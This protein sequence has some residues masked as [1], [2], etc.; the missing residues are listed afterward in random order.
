MGR[1]CCWDG[2]S[3]ARPAWRARRAPELRPRAPALPELPAHLLG[4]QLLAQ[5]VERDE[6]PGQQA[7]LQEALGHQHDLA[8]QLEVGHHHRAGP[9]RGQQV[10]QAPPTRVAL[11]RPEG[12]GGHAALLV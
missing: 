6:L 11:S 8:D 9:A 1:A 7:G 4:E 5:G 3:S 12:S 10:S 2:W